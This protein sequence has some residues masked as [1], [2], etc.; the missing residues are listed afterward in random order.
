M[1]K[2]LF[3]VMLCSIGFTTIAQDIIV[4]NDKSEIKAKVLEISETAI[5]YKKFEMLEGPTYSIKKTEVF[6][7]MYQN[8]TKEFIHTNQAKPV[9]QQPTNTITTAMENTTTNAQKSSS[10][11]KVK[12]KRFGM[13]VSTLLTNAS[14]GVETTKEAAFRLQ[15]GFYYA[16]PLSTNLTLVPSINI[17][18]KG[19]NFSYRDANTISDAS[20]NTSW[21]EIP[22]T[23]Q[24]AKGNKGFFV[25]LAPT[26]SICIAQVE[27]GI[28]RDLNTN[29]TYSF[30]N[31][32]GFKSFAI[33]TQLGVG[34]RLS[35]NT[36]LGV[37]YYT[38]ITDISSTNISYK[39]NYFG[40]SLSFGL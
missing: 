31:D 14:I 3:L 21:I 27:K 5:M 37:L 18:G 25:T 24:Y 40:L 32:P 2:M 15:A 28:A 23:L 36:K 39:P 9:V 7:I 8:G 13:Q 12:Q 22:F 26:A 11:T 34:Y 20:I 16:M 6:M 17:V 35:T 10:G 1:K 38:S 30:E 29:T 4:K 19:V 33:G